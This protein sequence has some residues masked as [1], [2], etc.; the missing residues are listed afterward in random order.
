MIQ[1]AS[2]MEAAGVILLISTLVSDFLYCSESTLF[3]FI[4][5]NPVY[6]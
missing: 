1:N 2:Y 6:L 4:C 5:I 3:L